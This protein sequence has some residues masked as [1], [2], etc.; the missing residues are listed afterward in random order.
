MPGATSKIFD[1]TK[2]FSK[3]YLKENMMCVQ[4]TSPYVLLFVCV[5]VW[6]GGIV[7]V[8]KAKNSELLATYI[9]AQVDSV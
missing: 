6:G 4:Y 8:N 5:C 2:K 7:K 9:Y 1:K 3:K